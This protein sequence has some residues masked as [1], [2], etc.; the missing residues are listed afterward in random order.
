MP[1]LRTPLIRAVAEDVSGRIQLRA[2]GVAWAGVAVLLLG[3]AWVCLILAVLGWLALRWG[4]PMAGM[5]VAL[6]LGGL[7]WACLLLARRAERDRKRVQRQS[8][9]ALVAAVA[10]AAEA[11][12]GLAPRPKLLVGAGVLLG[13]L[14]LLLSRRPGPGD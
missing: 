13:A 8:S 14:L 4:M 7:A 1:D 3:T 5:A 12:P 6:A 11:L 10:A 9:E 2:R